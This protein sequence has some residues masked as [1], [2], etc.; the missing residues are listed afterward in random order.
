L[1]LPPSGLMDCYYKILK[2]IDCIIIV[3]RD[4]PVN[5][6]NR[7]VFYDID[8]NPIIQNLSKSDKD[9]YLKAIK[10]DI[11]YFGRTYMRAHLSVNIDNISIEECVSKIHCL[12]SNY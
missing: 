1:A 3:L 2:R 6:L 11:S 4:N 9:Y 7:L 5:I 10:K 8:S 12:L